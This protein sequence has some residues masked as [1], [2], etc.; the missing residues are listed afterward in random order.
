MTRVSTA[1][2]DTRSDN[3]RGPRPESVQK[4]LFE[5]GSTIDNGG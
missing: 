4:Q 2:H 1:E 5:A 3:Q